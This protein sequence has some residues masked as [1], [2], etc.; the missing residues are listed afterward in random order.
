MN[1][2]ILGMALSEHRRAVGSLRRGGVGSSDGGEL[3]GSFPNCC[4]VPPLCSDEHFCILNKSL[5]TLIALDLRTA[6]LPKIN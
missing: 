4:V 2:C 5:R 1:P 6:G 3:C